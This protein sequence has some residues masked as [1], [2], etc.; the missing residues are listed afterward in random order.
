VDFQRQ[1]P[2]AEALAWAERALGGSARVVA[3]RRL[4]GG[5][6]AAVHRLTIESGT[7]SGAGRQVV[8]LRQYEQAAPDRVLREGQVL[9]AAVAAGLPAPEPLGMSADGADAGGHPSILMTRLRGQMNLSPADPGSWL[10]Q[11]AGMT[12]RVEEVLDTALRRL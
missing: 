6:P 9:A 11:I 1:G 10:R 3:Y 4:T 5:I 8:V 2:S 7:E 12:A